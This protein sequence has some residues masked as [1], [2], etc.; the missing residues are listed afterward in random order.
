M[1]MM[2]VINK[3][4]PKGNM[5]KW[6]CCGVGGGLMMSAMSAQAALPETVKTAIDNAKLDAV[7]AG[8]LVVGVVAALFVVGIVKRLLR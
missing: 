4:A 3:Y 7:E 6:V 8:W 5:K 2:S 1:K